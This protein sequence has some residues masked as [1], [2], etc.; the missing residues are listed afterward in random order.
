MIKLDTG[1]K[2]YILMIN[3]SFKPPKYI[4]LMNML[5]I[6]TG[7]LGDVVRTSFIAQALKEKNR[8]KET[9]LYWVTDEGAK[10]LFINNVYVDKVF[11]IQNKEEIDSLKNLFFEIVINLEED[12]EIC[13]FVSSLDYKE[14]RGFYY[15]DGAIL[16][17]PSTKE[18]YDMSELGKKPQNDILKRKN[19]KAHR[20]IISEIVG[21][22]DNKRYEPFLR[23]TKKQRK[24]SEDFLRWHNLSKF[25]LIIGINTGSADRWPKHLSVKKTVSL[26]NKISKK[27]R[28][29]FILFGGPYEV[30]RNR[31]II[32]KSNALIIDTGCGNNLIEFP[33]LISVCNLFITT[34]S[35]GLHLAL[36]L[37]R[38]TI[39]LVGP[40]SASEI[41]MYGLG[42]KVIA[43]SPCT[44]C[45]KSNCKSMEKIDLEEIFS[46]TKKLL[47][48]K[49][50][51]LITAYKEP[52]VSKAIEAALNQKTNYDYEIIVSVPDKETIEIVKEYSKK[53]KRVR[54]F[55]D[56]GKG[57]SYALNLAFSEIKTDILILTDGDVYISENS[58]EEIVKLFSDPEIGCVSGR[59]FPYETRTNR[60]GYWANFLFD[61][62]HR[63]RKKADK[64]NAF[65]ECSGY[66]FAFRKENINSI[67]LDVA[68]DTVIPYI[69]WGK[70]Y[71]IG[72]CDSAKVYVKNASNIKDWIRQ[73]IRT[74]KSH[75]KLGEYVDIQTTPKIK[76]FRTEFKG[77]VWLAKYPQNFKE[78][79]WTIELALS[80]FYTWGKFFLDTHFFDRH[81]T[82][83]WE[84]IESTK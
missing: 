49:I 28:A 25:D 35:L 38:K 41:D 8:F 81:Y 62:A 4:S 13:E 20:Q 30:E 19:K 31:E 54:L 65:I 46:V 71:K 67:P 69:F 23:L 84:R 82:D 18:W 27:Y 48:Q 59:P 55:E 11:S 72:Y 26:I 68:E 12:T 3:N 78:F 33:A 16:P 17:T 77:V 43:K 15:K 21:I 60:Y 6:K 14:L 9:N 70:G 1:F 66:L 37:K 76:S 75:G 29:K 32:S 53:D 47:K 79:F 56:P 5:I 44:C 73:K 57:K 52:K 61:A 80:R 63:I 74:H 24:F 58:V 64:L 36:A 50:T 45:Y 22:K 51:L 2:F 40:T 39:V 10:P 42:E 34:D 7:A 83:A